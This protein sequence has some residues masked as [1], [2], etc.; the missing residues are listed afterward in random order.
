MRI[1]ISHTINYS[2]RLAGAPVDA[3]PAPHAA[4]HHAPEGARLDARARPGQP[5]RTHDGYGNVLHVLTI[6]KPVSEIAIQARR[7]RRDRGGARRAVGFHRHAA[8]AAALPAADRPDARR[9]GARPPSPKDSGAARP[10]SP[11]C[12][13]SPRA[14]HQANGESSAATPRTPSSPAA[15]TS[16]CRRATFRATSTRRRSPP[17]AARCTPGP[18]PGSSSAGAASTSRRAAPI[19]EAPH[20]DRD[21]RGLPRRLPDARR[22]HR[23]RHRNADRAGTDVAA[24]RSND[25]PRRPESRHALPLRP[26]DRAQPAGGAPAP[27]AACA[28]AGPR[29]FAARSRPRS[30]SSTGSRTRSRTGSRASCSR[31]RRASFRIEVDLVAEMSVINPFDF[32]LEPYAE[33]LPVQVRACAASRA[34]A[35]PD[36]TAR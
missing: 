30:T 6:D 18:R 36:E 2:L 10:R 7:Q 23:R 24:D 22:A 21:R 9:R 14:I 26:R 17:T 25:D 29:L 3:V 1:S 8:L 31:R 5:M 12:A 33:K 16:A 35:L 13:S 27:R 32:F 19:G 11:A 20:Q 15:A 28:H 4:R 34:R